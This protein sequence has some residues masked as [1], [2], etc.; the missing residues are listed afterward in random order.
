VC[1]TLIEPA[2][3]VVSHLI[4]SAT[5]TAAGDVLSSL[6]SAISG[7]VRWAVVNTAAW[8]V[9]IPSPNLT[10]EPTVTA[11][12]PGCCRSPPPWRSPR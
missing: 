6:A 1:N 2:C 7:G 12:R 9:T 10:A 5:A 3:A 8:W 11:I 4:G